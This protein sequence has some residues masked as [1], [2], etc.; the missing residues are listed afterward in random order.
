MGRAFRLPCRR[1]DGGDDPRRPR[2]RRSR[3]RAGK[4]DHRCAVRP[5]LLGRRPAAAGRR[6]GAA[7]RRG[8]RPRRRPAV[9]GG[10]EGARRNRRTRRRRRRHPPPH[11]PP[12]RRMHRLPHRPR[13][14]QRRRR[15]RLASCSY[16]SRPVPTTIAEAPRTTATTGRDRSGRRA[17]T[18]SPYRAPGIGGLFSSSILFFLCI[19]LPWIREEEGW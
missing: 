12:Q 17:P 5:L 6:D 3:R 7:P 9:P 2:P 19:I 14:R 15:D 10:R 18:P 16:H 8:G 13:R 4:G 11:R 1:L